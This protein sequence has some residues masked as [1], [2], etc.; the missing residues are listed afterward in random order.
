MSRTITRIGP[1]DHGRRMDLD[2]FAEAE[3]QE[4]RIYELGRGIVT[5][6]EIPKKRHMLQV[7][8]V[9]DQLQAYKALYA[10][11]IAVIAAGSECKLIIAALGSER[12]PD[13]AVY[14]TPPPEHEDD[15]FWTRWVPEIVVEV[16]SPSS[17]S[18]D[19]NEKPEEYLRAGVKEYWI[20]DSE[21]GALI[22]MRRSRGRW[23]RTEV[24]PP[25]VYRTRLLP[26]LAFSI[27]SVFQSAGLA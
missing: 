11:R 26:G 17:R 1:A 24:A 19:Y 25:S 4:G 20:V 27:G 7:A 6:V 23:I 13:L 21:R 16:V 14:L 18:R 3:G 2:E 12:H 5:V 15:E 8:A 9:R 10:G 22:V